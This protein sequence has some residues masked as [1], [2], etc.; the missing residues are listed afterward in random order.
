M[1]IIEYLEKTGA[2]VASFAGLA[3]VDAHV[4]HRVIA[5]HIPKVA[6]AARLA[7]ATGGLVTTQE[8][9]GLPLCQCQKLA[10]AVRVLQH[11][12]VGL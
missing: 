11:G 3:G 8:I 2:T 9:L 1:Q 6:T 10:G 5:G 7:D 4:V 12:E